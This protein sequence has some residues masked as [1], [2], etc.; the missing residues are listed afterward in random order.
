MLVDL[1]GEGFT[2]RCS[3]ITGIWVY[4]RSQCDRGIQL[5]ALIVLGQFRYLHV[6]VVGDPNVSHM[7]PYDNFGG[8]GAYRGD[9]GSAQHGPYWCAGTTIVTSAHLGAYSIVELQM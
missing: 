6:V 5:Q 2:C 1:V 3:F 9:S 7:T 8:R 4:R